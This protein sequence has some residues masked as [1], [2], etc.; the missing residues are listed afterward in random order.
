MWMTGMEVDPGGSRDAS[1][2]WTGQGSELHPSPLA[3]PLTRKMRLLR[4]SMREIPR[5]K[6]RYGRLLV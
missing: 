6:E 5:A 4:S 2:G 3:M 1:Y